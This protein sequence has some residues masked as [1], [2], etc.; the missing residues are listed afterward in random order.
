MTLTLQHTC[1]FHLQS[2]RI[3]HL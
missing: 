2:N 1:I 3:C